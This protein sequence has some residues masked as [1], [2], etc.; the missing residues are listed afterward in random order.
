MVRS[1]ADGAT[2]PGA[3]SLVATQDVA[4]LSPGASATFPTR[5]TIGDD[6]PAGDYFLSAVA[7]FGLTVA[8]A[9]TSNDGLS[10]AVPI[11]VK[12]NL[13][14]FKSASA[15]FSQTSPP[16]PTAPAGFGPLD[17]TCDAEGSVNLTGTFQ[18]NSQQGNSAQGQ[19]NLTGTLNDSPVQYLISFAGSGSDNGSVTAVLNSVVFRSLTTPLTGNGNGSLVGTLQGR[20]LVASVS[21]QFATSTGGAC[22]FTGTLEAQAQTSFQLRTGGGLDDLSS[23]G[24]GFTPSE[25]P[26]FPVGPTGGGAEFRVFFDTNYPDPSTVRFTGPAGSGITN[27]PA[28]S[29]D[30]GQGGDGARYRTGGDHS[31]NL[32]GG[33]WTVLYKGQP[34]T[35][36]MPSFNANGSFVVVFPTVT[37][38]AND[39]LTRIDWVY[40]NRQNGSVLATVPSFIA[41]INV[42]VEVNSSSGDQPESTMLSPATQTFD[43]VAAGFSAKWSKVYSV[44]FQYV[45]FAG[46]IYEQSYGKAFSVQLSPRLENVYGNFFCNSGLAGTSGCLTRS[47]DVFVNVPMNSVNRTNCQGGPAPFFVQIQN[48]DAV[49]GSPNATLPYNDPTCIFWTGTT[50]FNNGSTST[51]IFSIGTD[52]DTASPTGG[53][54]T[55]SAGTKF[56]ITISTNLTDPTLDVHTIVATLD[57]PEADPAVDVVRIPGASGVG[58]LGST[59][60]D[61]KLGQ[62]QTISWTAPS[63]PVRSLFINPVVSTSPTGQGTFCSPNLPDLAPGTTQAT[64]TFP[65]TCNGQAVQQASVCI[66]YEGENGETSDACWFFSNQGG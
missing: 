20:T 45:D 31:G 32:P 48:D 41:G 9:D 47:L 28:D 30:S 26:A 64:F 44:R 43:I 35:F 46:N 40:R 22:V 53:P 39:N 61:A 24:F 42:R 4:G 50:N 25:P 6:F 3:G 21:G 59:L 66:F 33:T 38:D 37:V 60:A 17:V 34:H 16:A 18:I 63:F 58:P 62:A 2:A 19:A 65:A 7:N 10:S 54:V 52:L 5:V 23:F 12:S 14:K 55:L 11:S 36:T 15:A 57:S 29:H 56:D 13:T 8:E 1:D 49:L 27:Q 51:D